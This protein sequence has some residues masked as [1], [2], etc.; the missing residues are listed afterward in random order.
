MSANSSSSLYYH[1]QPF[2]H[3]EL[4]WHTAGEVCLVFFFESIYHIKESI[5]GICFG[6]EPA[7]RWLC[8]RFRLIF[9][10]GISGLVPSPQKERYG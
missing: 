5:V 9:V 6:G 7:L 10:R 2:L 3:R 4:H 1:G 8:V